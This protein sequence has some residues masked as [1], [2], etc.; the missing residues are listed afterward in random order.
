M[1]RR[2]RR[3]PS[4]SDVTGLAQIAMLGGLAY[5]FY[6]Y[7]WPL[8]NKGASAVASPIANAYVALTSGPAITATKQVMLPDGTDIPMQQIGATGTLKDTTQPDGTPSATFTWQGVNYTII[9]GADDTG[10]Y[11]AQAS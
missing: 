1:R 2:R 4:L 6:K 10:T 3:N 8:F 7:V 5:L 11:Y 9:G